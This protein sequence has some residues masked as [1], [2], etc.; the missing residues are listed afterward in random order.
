MIYKTLF[1]LD[2]NDNIRTWF[3]EQDGSQYRTHSGI[4]GG[5]IVISEWKQATAKNVGKT[6]ATSDESQATAEIEA[7]YQKKL[8]RKYSLTPDTAQRSNFVQPMLADKFH[9]TK[10]FKTKKT[11][12]LQPKLDGLR[13]VMDDTGGTSR[14]GK[15]FHTVAHLVAKL[16][17]AALKYNVTFD[18]ELYNHS[19]KEDFEKIVSLVKKQKLSSLTD[20]ELREIADKVEFHIYDVIFWDNLER[21]YR[22][23]LDFLEEIFVEDFS[24]STK[25][26]LVEAIQIEGLD[27]ERVQQAHDKYFAEGYEGLMLRDAD[28]PYEFKRSKGLLKY[29]NFD[30]DEFELVDII[31]GQGN[32]SGAAKAVVVKTPHGESEAGVAGTYERNKEIWENP[33]KYIGGQVT[34]KYQG[35][36][37]DNK[38]R[39]GV[40]K[41]FHEGKRDY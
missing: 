10:T 9:E 27:F 30:E 5:K 23:R 7:L 33:K 20:E 13:C 41:A 2:N 37:K 16:D 24:T 18:G 38:L 34:V 22:E 1:H 32:W 25:I 40:V 15:P 35:Y 36:T 11:W 31:E 26:K 19:Y 39:F 6:N 17:E 21:P 28:S 14:A 29:K 3:M 4:E 12:I 8:D